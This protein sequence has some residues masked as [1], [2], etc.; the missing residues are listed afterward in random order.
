MS[1]FY[2]LFFLIL[3][4]ANIALIIFNIREAVI[5]ASYREQNIKRLKEIEKLLDMADNFIKEKENENEHN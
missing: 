1:L 4:I 2:E 5:L 3:V